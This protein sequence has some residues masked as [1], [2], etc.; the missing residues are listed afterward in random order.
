MKILRGVERRF[1][2]VDRPE[3]W[4]DDPT[5]FVYDPEVDNYV[6]VQQPTD[7]TFRLGTMG[8]KY[9]S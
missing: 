9:A 7:A 6:E 3:G 8:M 4:V 1:T 2:P 5:Q